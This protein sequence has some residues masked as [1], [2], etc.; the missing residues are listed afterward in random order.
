MRRPRR[1]GY[2]AHGAVCRHRSST[3][4]DQPLQGPPR[5]GSSA[6]ATRVG[7]PDGFPRGASRQAQGASGAGA[8]L[9]GRRSRLSAP[10][11][12]AEVQLVLLVPGWEGLLCWDVAPVADHPVDLVGTPPVPLCAIDAR[13]TG[14]PARVKGHCDEA[15]SPRRAR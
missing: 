9:N 8:L 3:L 12:P 2:S 10:V 5:V 11:A 14:P 15:P 4:L 1:S 7:F 13:G 6:G